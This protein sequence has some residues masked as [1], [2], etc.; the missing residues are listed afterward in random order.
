MTKTGGQEKPKVGSKSVPGKA[1]LGEGQEDNARWLLA[2]DRSNAA[3][4]YGVF[5]VGTGNTTAHR[6]SYRIANGALK[7]GLVIDHLCRNRS[8]CNPLHLEEVTSRENT[9]RGD[10]GRLHVKCAN[11][12]T[13]TEETTGRHRSGRRFCLICRRT[14]DRGRRDASY[15]REYRRKKKARMEST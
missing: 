15:W 14:R 3:N 5:F 2:M 8:C 10:K 4:G 11:G 1:V 13:F 7:D 6:A 9:L 12:H